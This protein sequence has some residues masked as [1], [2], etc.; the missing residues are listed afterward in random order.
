VTVADLRQF[1]VSLAAPLEAGGG[2]SAA[3]DLRRA[4]DA[5]SPFAALSLP[6]F[7]DFLARAKNYAETGVVATSAARASRIKPPDT[8]TIRAAAESYQRLYE[9]CTDPAVGDDE[10]VSQMTALNRLTKDAVIGVA[11]EVG[12]HKSFKTKKDALAE[13]RRRIMDRKETYERVQLG[14]SSPRAAP[15]GT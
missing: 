14:S 6:A 2:K 13:M 12:I 9:R 10:I 11:R 1:L 5:L 7:A 3:A 15:A 4:A 8:D